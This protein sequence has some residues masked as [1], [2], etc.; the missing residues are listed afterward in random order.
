M[1]SFKWLSLKNLGSN[2]LG[3]IQNLDPHRL[4]SRLKSK[5]TPGGRF[6]P[7]IPAGEEPGGA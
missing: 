3:Q 1:P 2:T 4:M 5:T 6:N 7:R